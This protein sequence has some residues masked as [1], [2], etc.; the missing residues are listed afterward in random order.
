MC[1]RYPGRRVKLFMTFIK[2][3]NKVM[4]THTRRAVQDKH[5]KARDAFSTSQV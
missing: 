4:A 1:E 5:T 3:T 2:D